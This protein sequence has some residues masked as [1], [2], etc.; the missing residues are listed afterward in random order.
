MKTYKIILNCL[1][2]VCA[3]TAIQAQEHIERVHIQTFIRDIQAG[4]VTFDI[5]FSTCEE[6]EILYLGESDI[7]FVLS[8][9][10]VEPT[11]SI[12]ENASES[13]FNF[14]TTNL[15]AGVASSYGSEIGIDATDHEMFISISAPKPTTQTSF[16]NKVA[17]IDNQLETH[18]LGRFIVKGYTGEGEPQFELKT[19][20]GG[21]VTEI[22]AFENTSPFI[23]YEVSPKLPVS[24]TKFKAISEDNQVQLKWTTHTEV[25]SSHFEVQHSIT[26]HNWQ[27]IEK[28][29]AAG[30]SLQPLD[31]EH[32]HHSPIIGDNYYRLKMID[33]D[34]S[35]EYSN[36][37]V[38]RFEHSD[39]K[40][41]IY[42]NP[43]NGKFTVTLRV[44][45]RHQVQL[46]VI[47]AAGKMIYNEQTMLSNTENAV[48]DLSHVAKGTYLITVKTDK[49]QFAERLI[50]Y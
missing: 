45:T 24:L 23:L 7:R 15:E 19:S 28:V 11:S 26:N 42:P 2:T 37:E 18:R 29:D 21:F 50:I 30:N 34:G 41:V 14:V 39:N 20:G 12:V 49:E 10:F 5:Y 13:Y 36:T 9:N 38:V 25:N 27:S 1:Y 4:E 22:F 40:M 8:Q 3:C 16:D 6:G 33:L 47:D 31:Y 48:I 17:S 46:S 43:T 44:E 32:I 35:Y